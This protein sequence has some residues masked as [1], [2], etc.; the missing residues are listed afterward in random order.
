MNKEEFFAILKDTSR[1]NWKLVGAQYE[2]P[3]MVRCAA[4]DCPVT[5]VTRKLTGKSFRTGD[6]RE[7][8]AE[9]G[10]DYEVGQEIVDA[11]DFAQFTSRASHAAVRKELLAVCGIEV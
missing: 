1:G 5:A 3:T 4:D 9:I 11:A 7:A 8:A 6:W 10:L 2:K